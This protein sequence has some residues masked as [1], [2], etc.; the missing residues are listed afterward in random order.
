MLNGYTKGNE[1]YENNVPRKRSKKKQKTIGQYPLHYD[2]VEQNLYLEPAYF[3]EKQNQCFDLFKYSRHLL[4]FY[5]SC[6]YLY[7]YIYI[8]IYIYI[9]IYI[10][11]YLY[12]YI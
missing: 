2:L 8:C 3:Q 7:I 11:M 1:V 4:L 10:Y 5:Q 9:Y 6:V 12:I